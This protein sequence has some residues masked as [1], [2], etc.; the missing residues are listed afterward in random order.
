VNRLEAEQ[1]FSENLYQIKGKVIVILPV[2]WSSLRVEDVTLLNKILA[3]VKHSLDGVQILSLQTTSLNQLLSYEPSA[4][5]LFDVNFTPAV[6]PFS[7]EIIEG[8]TV[9]ASDALDQLD[10]AKKKSL[11]GALKQAFKL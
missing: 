7:S 2:A 6:K 9:I 3:S 5:I 11:W 1:I 10:D 4:I 8:V